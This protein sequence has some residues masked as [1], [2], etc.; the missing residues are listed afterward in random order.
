MMVMYNIY[1]IHLFLLIIFSLGMVTAS[2]SNQCLDPGSG[3]EGVLRDDVGKSEM[4]TQDRPLVL[5]EGYVLKIINSRDGVD[6]KYLTFRLEKNEGFAALEEIR[7]SDPFCYL[8]NDKDLVIYLEFLA[9]NDTRPVA[10]AV[11]I[12]QKSDK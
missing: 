7:E 1:K 5:S 4:I 2:G 9:I 11:R 10:I 8:K 12:W 6:G 3:D